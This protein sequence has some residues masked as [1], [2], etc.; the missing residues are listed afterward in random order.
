MTVHFSNNCPKS[1]GGLCRNCGAGGRG[2]VGRT[3][4]GMCQIRV[5]LAHNDD[6]FIPSTWLILDTW[7]TSIVGKNIDMFKNI[8]GFLEEERLTVV[9]NGG[10]RSFNEIGKYEIFPIEAHFNLHSMYNI[11]ALKDM[12]NVTGVRITIDSSNERAITV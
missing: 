12:A 6:G 7:Y 1:P 5:G 10:N 4:T 2:Y 8:R 11:V 9:T 3:G